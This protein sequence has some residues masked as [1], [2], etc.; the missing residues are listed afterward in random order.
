[1]SKKGKIMTKGKIEELNLQLFSDS[2]NEGVN[3]KSGENFAVDAEQNNEEKMISSEDEFESLIGGK[4]KEQFTKKVQGIIDKRFKETK[5]LE[6]YKEKVSPIINE[7]NEK[8]GDLKN[9]VHSWVKEG[10]GLKEIYPDF[11]FKNEVKA[12]P[13]FAKLLNSGVS[14]K[15][16]YE[17]IHK[18]EILSGAMAYTAERVREQVVRGIEAKGTRPTENGVN[19]QSGI[20]T[21]TDVNSLTKKDI[22]KIIKQV[23]GGANIKF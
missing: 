2:T 14:L 18:D 11:D 1:M 13:L 10:E 3:S 21:V 6:A 5:E 23:E 22:L 19:A 15:S 17:V 20:V 12:N 16:A 7:L 9:R 4:F 8:N